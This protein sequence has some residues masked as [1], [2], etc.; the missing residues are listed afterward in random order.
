MYI[1]L[2]HYFILVPLAQILVS[3]KNIYTCIIISPKLV[4]WTS[5]IL[6][7]S[8]K[9]MSSQNITHKLQYK[10]FHVRK[11]L[12]FLCDHHGG[13]LTETK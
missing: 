7:V 9:I 4:Y 8:V 10:L 12:H 1:L 6:K 2:K 13:K 5:L 11:T 3:L